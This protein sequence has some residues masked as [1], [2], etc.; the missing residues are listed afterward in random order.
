MSVTYNQVAPKIT[1][2]WD[3]RTQIT[4]LNKAKN[5]D[6]NNKLLQLEK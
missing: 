5:T 3:L 4:R 1:D 6:K 2:T